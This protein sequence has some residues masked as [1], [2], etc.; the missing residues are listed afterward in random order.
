MTELNKEYAVENNRVKIQKNSCI[1]VFISYSHD[2]LEHT[3]RVLEFS[4]RLIRDGVNCILDQYT[5]APKEGWVKWMTNNLENS[6]YIITVC[7]SLYNERIKGNQ[8]SAR[9]NGV[10][11]ESLLTLQSL[12]ENGSINRNIV[13]VVFNEKDTIFIPSPFKS[14][15]YYSLDSNMGYEELYR[16]ITNQP[17]IM[18]PKL[19]EKIK[20][21]TGINLNKKDIQII[22]K[23]KKRTIELVIEEDFDTY[24]EED[25]AQLLSAI[26]ELLKVK[27]GEV[28]IKGIRKGSVVISLEIPE[29]LVSN[30]L[31][32]QDEGELTKL[33]ISSI[34]IDLEK[35]EALK[36]SRIKQKQAKNSANSMTM[37]GTVKWF[38]ESKGF[39]FIEQEG[40]PDVFVHYSAISG[41]GRKTLTSGQKIEF[42]VEESNKSATSLNIVS[43]KSL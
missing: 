36:K 12:Y 37:T 31:K 3:N 13:P 41:E 19:G 21:E 42:E 30:I 24:S 33:K 26:G 7:T 43:F 28:L 35:R 32:L 15:R 29:H 34:C 23:I 22:Q 1:T 11:F 5:P 4:D 8:L 25:K 20:L 14:F 10:R 40:G 2:S 17:K 38:N 16:H 9:G 18:K 6:D 27:D 39:G